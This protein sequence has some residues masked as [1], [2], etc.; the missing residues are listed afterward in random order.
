MNAGYNDD[1]EASYGEC[2]IKLPDWVQRRENGN[3][4][5]VWIGEYSSEGCDLGQPKEQK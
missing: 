5:T 4:R 3:G 1:G 2:E